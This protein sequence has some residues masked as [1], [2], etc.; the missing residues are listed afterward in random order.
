MVSGHRRW[1]ILVFLYRHRSGVD[2]AFPS[3]SESAEG[4]L[5]TMKNMLYSLVFLFLS[6]NSSTIFFQKGNVYQ[7]VWNII[8]SNSMRAVGPHHVREIP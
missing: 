5:V 4:L 2:P 6:S 1:N 3:H 8:S 7:L